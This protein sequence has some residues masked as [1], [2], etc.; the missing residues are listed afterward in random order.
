M[1]EMNDMQGKIA[2]LQQPVAQQAEQP[3]CYPP[4]R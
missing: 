2:L 3:R 1:V 4:R